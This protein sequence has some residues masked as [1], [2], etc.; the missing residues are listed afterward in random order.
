MEHI[1]TSNPNIQPLF[2][3]MTFSDVYLRLN[4]HPS[5]CLMSKC[6]WVAC[7]DRSQLSYSMFIFRTVKNGRDDVMHHPSFILTTTVIRKLCQQGIYFRLVPRYS[8][9]IQWD[10]QFLLPYH[11]IFLK[12]PK[13][14]WHAEIS[15]SLWS[16]SLLNLSIVLNS[17]LQGAQHP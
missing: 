3:N 11:F 12:L 7:C 6:L 13:C 2:I 15:V 4:T 5:P 14:P 9:Q 8:R 1:N 16:F 10:L 17:P